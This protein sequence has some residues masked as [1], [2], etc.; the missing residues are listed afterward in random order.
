MTEYDDTPD[1]PRPSRARLGDDGTMD[2][3][4]CC[5]ECGEEMRYT[6]AAGPD[7]QTYYDP[8]AQTYDEFVAW[9]MEDFDEDHECEEEE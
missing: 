8:D 4:I 9:A 2:T 3:V 7:D 1:V 5:S 6:Y